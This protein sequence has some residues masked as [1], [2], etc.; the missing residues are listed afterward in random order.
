[1]SEVLNVKNPQDSVKAG[2]VY[3]L[4]DK[5]VTV[6]LKSVNVQAK[7]LDLVAR[8]CLFTTICISQHL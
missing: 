4:D 2:L 1:M 5:D 3:T 7:L 8:V 6:P